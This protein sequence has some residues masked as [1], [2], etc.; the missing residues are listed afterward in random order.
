MVHEWNYTGGPAGVVL[1]IGAMLL[2]AGGMAWGVADPL[3]PSKDCRKIIGAQLATVAKIAR[4]SAD[5]CHKEKNKLVPP[6]A[7]A[8]CNDLQS[9][10]PLM[11]P[12]G[13]YPLAV[14]KATDKIIGAF[15]KCV[16]G[17]PV[18]GLYAGGDPIA[19][20]IPR[21]EEAVEENSR[22]LEGDVA[23]GN[24]DEARCIDTIAAQ[25]SK[26]INQ[27]VKTA[28]KCQ[29]LADNA[30]SDPSE[31]SD[32]T[33]ACEDEALTAAN[34]PVKGSIPKGAATITSKCIPPD[35]TLPQGVCGDLAVSP[36]PGCA[37]D[38]ATAVGLR[39]AR[40]IVSVVSEPPAGQLQSTCGVPTGR[41]TV[42]VSLNVPGLAKLAGAQINVDYPQFQT[43]LPSRN[44]APTVAGKAK[45][46]QSPTDGTADLF[47]ANDLD[48]E[49]VTLVAE[50]QD[51]FID[52]GPIL[53]VTLDSCVPRSYNLC[54]RQQNVTGC[55]PAGLLIPDPNRVPLSA[56]PCATAVRACT[57]FD[58]FN[59]PTGLY[60]E[61][62]QGCCPA[63]D[64]CGLQDIVTG[65]A[66]SDPVDAD[67]NSVP[68]VTCT[69][70]IT[71][72]N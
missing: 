69:V 21:I 70:S 39:I 18:L 15:R 33:Q 50:A 29:K 60:R 27:I 10:D 19:A 45:L 53:E 7:G 72:S 41:R 40:A 43:S 32:L 8:P 71:G 44:G 58:P 47:L 26:I 13:K 31:F 64:A 61:P 38:A 12:D 52:D 25:R 48:S 11:D 23:Q 65:C 4:V 1:T 51:A 37:T 3:K 36:L 17:E 49:L 2:G 68:G 57:G 34:D 59:P 22:R 14:S 67:G 6:A 5:K 54:L 66:V 35:G 56:L 24:K 30:A 20:A 9:G 16:P 42:T 28:V 63:D 55:C 46:L 62:P